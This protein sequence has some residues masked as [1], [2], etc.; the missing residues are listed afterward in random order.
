MAPLPCNHVFHIII[1]R[2]D[3]QWLSSRRRLYLQ[4][5]LWVDICILTVVIIAVTVM[6]SGNDG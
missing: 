5:L 6:L 4:R 2:G 3:Q 1:N